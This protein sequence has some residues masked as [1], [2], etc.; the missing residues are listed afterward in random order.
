MKSCSTSQQ[1]K[2]K[3]NIHKNLSDWQKS[4][5][6]TQA[7]ILSIRKLKLIKP[8]QIVCIYT[9]NNRVRNGC[10]FDFSPSTNIFPLHVLGLLCVQQMVVFWILFDLFDVKVEFSVLKFIIN[11]KGIIYMIKHSKIE[12]D[13]ST[14]YFRTHC[15]T[16]TGILQKLVAFEM[17]LTWVSQTI[18]ALFNTISEQKQCLEPG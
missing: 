12:Q 6:V 16:L 2:C 10:V 1:K 15:I 3:T 9:I 13:C 5:K 7:Y 8:E 11:M 17:F 18:L 4:K 14:F